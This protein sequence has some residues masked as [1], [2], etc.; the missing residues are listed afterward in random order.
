MSVGN[1]SRMEADFLSI[2]AARA[3]PGLVRDVHRR[4]REIHVWTVNDLNNVLK[5]IAMGVDNIITDQPADVRNWVNGWSEL[6]DSERVALMLGSLIVNLERAR[7][8]DL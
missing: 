2:S 1:P 3:T 6:S 7:P 5:M 8:T 4:G